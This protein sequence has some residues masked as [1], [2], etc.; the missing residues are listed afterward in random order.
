MTDERNPGGRPRKRRLTY[1]ETSDVLDILDN[2]QAAGVRHY[3]LSIDMGKPSNWLTKR[4][5]RASLDA[6]D[7]EAGA[8]VLNDA[9]FVLEFIGT[10]ITETSDR[11][12]PRILAFLLGRVKEQP[13]ALGARTLIERQIAH[14]GRRN[15]DDGFVKVTDNDPHMLEF[16][17]KNRGDKVANVRLGRVLPSRNENPKLFD[18]AANARRLLSYLRVRYNLVP[19]EPDLSTVAGIVRARLRDGD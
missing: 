13:S 19:N 1:E 11:D 15:K 14:L 10:Q 5:Y 12:D 2:V 8:M 4:I 3:R 6:V 17:A 7:D 18:A 9:L 16:V